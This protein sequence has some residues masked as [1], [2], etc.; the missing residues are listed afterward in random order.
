MVACQAKSY[1]QLNVAICT[2]LQATLPKLA[3]QGDDM[4]IIK[5]W[6]FFYGFTELKAIRLNKCDFA[7][8]IEIA[9]LIFVYK[10]K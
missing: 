6:F 4:F 10:K 7:K 9:L 5:I 8:L 3:I 1:S 2:T